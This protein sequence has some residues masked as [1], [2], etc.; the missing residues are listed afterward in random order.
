MVFQASKPKGEKRSIQIMS[1]FQCI[2]LRRFPFYNLF[3]L[4]KTLNKWIFGEF[5]GEQEHLKMR[6]NKREAIGVHATTPLFISLYM[7]MLIIMYMYLQ[8][9]YDVS[10]CTIWIVNR[11]HLCASNLFIWSNPRLGFNYWKSNWMLTQI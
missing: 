8:H 3:L 2:V 1:L 7:N 10:M 5:I 9:T 6:R 11:L 4:A